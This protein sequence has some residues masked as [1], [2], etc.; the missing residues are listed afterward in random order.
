MPLTAFHPV[1]ARWFAE[2]LGA[3]TAPQ[4]RGW[5]EIR[6][7]RHTLIAAPTG[8]GKTLAA[9][10]AA[11]DGLLKQGGELRDETS[12]LYISPLKALGNDVQKNLS[13]PLAELRALDP[14]LPEIRVLVRSGDTPQKDRAAMVRRPPHILVTTP[15]SFYILLTSVS[16]RAMLSTVRTVIV[17]E[18]HAVLGDKRGAH[19]ALSLERL[20]ALCGAVQRIGLS[21]TQKPLEDVGKF[22]G[23]VGREVALVD[24]G[25]LREMDLKVEIPSSP[26]ET[27]C[28]GETWMEIYERIAELVRS[29]RTTLVFVGTRKLAERVG[30]QLARLRRETAVAC[31]HSSLS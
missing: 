5:A 1:V 22:L 17:D 3:P 26:L 13:R 28:S 10:L 24:E 11:I 25:H 8:S 14:T 30:A 21:A 9:F 7:G 2:T 27:V 15:E 19:L 16:G 20:D 4:R 23:G 29:H 18:I 31:H 12:V 6:A